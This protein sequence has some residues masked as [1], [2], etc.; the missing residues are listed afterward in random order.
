MVRK[1]ASERRAAWTPK[2]KDMRVV[3]LPGV[4]VNVL[5]ELQLVAADG[6]EYVFVNG[7]GPAVGDRIKRGNIW[8]DFQTI[9]AKAGVPKCSFH[10]LRKS[11]CTNLAVLSRC[12]WHRSWPVTRTSVRHVSTT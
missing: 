11:Y 7:R 8:R 1:D 6:Q 3:P 2:N 12:M 9:R 5:T 10:D 4:A